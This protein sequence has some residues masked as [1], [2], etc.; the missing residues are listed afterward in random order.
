MITPEKLRQYIEGNL[1]WLGDSFK[2]LPKH[3]KEQVLWR[4]QICK[5]CVEQG[6]CKYC[7]CSVPGKLYVSKSC[8]DGEIFPDMM[9]KQDWDEYKQKNNIQIELW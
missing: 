8:N 4:A 5:D 1:K 9:D 2:L 6:Y 7:G 3:Q